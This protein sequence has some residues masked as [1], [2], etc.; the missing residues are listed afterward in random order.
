MSVNKCILVGRLGSDPEARYSQ[1]GKAVTNFGLATNE[2]WTDKSTGEKKERTEWHRIVTFGKLAEICRDNLAKS[3][4]VY[5]E[6]RLQTR[7][8]NDND[9]VK[10]YT[11]EIVA[12]TVRFLGSKPQSA[13]QE[14]PQPQAADDAP[15]PSSS[16]GPSLQEE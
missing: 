10:R 5:V 9:G 16:D 12:Q 6:G 15:P 2:Y 8:W 7:S 3:R 11:T 4:Q 14:T 13:P 1:S